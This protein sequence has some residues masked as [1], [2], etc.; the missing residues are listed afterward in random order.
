MIEIQKFDLLLASESRYSENAK[1]LLILMSIHTHISPEL[2]AW[3]LRKMDFLIGSPEIIIFLPPL[4]SWRTRNARIVCERTQFDFGTH[5]SP[6]RLTWF[7]P[8]KSQSKASDVFWKVPLK[9]SAFP[10][11]GIQMKPNRLKRLFVL[12]SHGVQTHLS[13]PTCFVFPSICQSIP[14]YLGRTFR[15]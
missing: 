9:I 8:S 15:F 4:D 1:L 5:V 3:S 6:N 7:L 10:Y 2:Q 12:T 13:S 14:F 11:S